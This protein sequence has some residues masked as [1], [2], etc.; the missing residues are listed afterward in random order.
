MYF[1]AKASGLQLSDRHQQP[2]PGGFIAAPVDFAM[3][4][5]A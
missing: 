3:V 5:A 4:T 2:P 1:R